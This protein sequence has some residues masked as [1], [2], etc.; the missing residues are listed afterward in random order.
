MANAVP[1]PPPLFTPPRPRPEPTFISVF[2]SKRAPLMLMWKRFTCWSPLIDTQRML[3]LTKCRL[4]LQLGCTSGECSA[5]REMSKK[6]NKISII[7]MLK[8]WIVFLYETFLWWFCMQYIRV[9][10]VNHILIFFGIFNHISSWHS[11]TDCQQLAWSSW[12]SLL[13]F[14]SLR[15]L[16]STR[17]TA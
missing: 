14:T 5:P 3:P 6:T 12:G 7:K 9:I 11:L 1:P 15:S 8:T 4:Y 10:I 17:L 2:R 13:S 16:G